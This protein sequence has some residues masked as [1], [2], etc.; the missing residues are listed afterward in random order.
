MKKALV[1][2]VL[3]MAV[4]ATSAVAQSAYTDQ[5]QISSIGT[6]GNGKGVE[7]VGG[8]FEAGGSAF[9]TPAKADTNFDSI[10]VGNDQSLAI[11]AGAVGGFPFASNWGNVQ[12]L[13]DL[14]IKKNQDTGECACCQ[15]IDSTCPCQD[16]CTKYNIEQITVG[17]RNALAIGAGAVGFGPF[18]F[19]AGGVT[20]HNNVEIIT[21][22]E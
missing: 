20:A 10:D 9:Q 17:N 7:M 18:A 14:V 5:G 1:L 22:Q 3:A 12:A 16:C 2:F 11:G 21:N 15:A 6:P 8:I 13:N 19:N 4:F